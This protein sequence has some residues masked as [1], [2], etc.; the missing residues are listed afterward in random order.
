MENENQE[1]SDGVLQ[2]L[3]AEREIKEIRAELQVIVDKLTYGGSYSEELL[4]AR[5]A[6][7]TGK[8]MLGLELGNLGGEDL[9]AKRDKAELS[10]DVSA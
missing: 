8:M 1:H 6:I 3:L 5:M 9:N 7:K 4:F 2:P 10:E